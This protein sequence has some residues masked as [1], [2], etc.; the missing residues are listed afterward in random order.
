LEKLSSTGLSWKRWILPV[1]FSLALHV[2]I[3]HKEIGETMDDLLD[4]IKIT[5]IKIQRTLHAPDPQEENEYVAELHDLKEDGML[6]RIDYGN[7]FLKT[8]RLKG[9]IESDKELESNVQKITEIIHQFSV[10]P[11]S[12]KEEFVKL[13][14]DVANSCGEPKEISAQLSGILNG[15]GGNCD[16]RFK[17]F[18]SIIKYVLPNASVKVVDE[19]NHRYLIVNAGYGWYK[20]D[21]SQKG[22]PVQSINI[23]DLVGV[24]ISDPISFVFAYMGEDVRP[25]LRVLNPGNYGGKE[26]DTDAFLGIPSES[27]KLRPHGYEPKPEKKKYPPIRIVRAKLAGLNKMEL[28]EAEKGDQPESSKIPQRDMS[29]EEV[30]QA[31]IGGQLDVSNEIG[32]FEPMRGV[33][34]DKIQFFGYGDCEGAYPSLDPLAVNPPKKISIDNSNGEITADFSV[35]N[36]KNIVVKEVFWTGSAKKLAD[37]IKFAK[38]VEYMA[39]V[40]PESLQDLAGME[41]ENISIGVRSNGEI[42]F[43]GIDKIKG[44]KRVIIDSYSLMC[45]GVRVLGQGSLDNT[46]LQDLTITENALKGM[47][48]RV[49]ASKAHVVL[50]KG[51]ITGLHYHLPVTTDLELSGTDLLKGSS[52]IIDLD[53]VDGMQLERIKLTSDKDIA[54][55]QAVGF[56]KTV[57]DLSPLKRQLSLQEAEVNG[58][59]YKVE[60]I[61]GLPGSFVINYAAK[62]F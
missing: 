34:L 12:N 41:I 6:D 27:K 51:S 57:L 45:I 30:I 54:A 19:A 25:L 24:Q 14:E 60:S 32:S 58:D 16:A 56:E 13:L 11:Q 22:S 42:D 15:E 17:Y 31:R 61:E 3:F 50:D 62:Q 33:P 49:R 23:S 29:D 9:S 4:V 38:R 37:K 26:V 52:G 8:E 44:L 10:Y 18:L 55:C 5:A 43:T 7:F 47:G 36:G 28:I 2:G 40:N 53:V 1:A 46:T 48:I 39:L 21:K 20:I 59:C 35:F